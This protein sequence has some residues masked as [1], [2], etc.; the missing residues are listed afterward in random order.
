VRTRSAHSRLLLVVSIAVFL[1]T[2]FYS[3]IT[4]LLP[5]LSHD[6]HL[7][8]LTAGVLTAS[9]PAGMLVASLPAGALAVRRGPR[10]T[11]ITGIC[12]LVLST[13]AFGLLNS[14]LALG[15][16]RFV[17]GIG[18][19]CSWAGGLAWIVSATPPERRGAVM[20]R[21]L[22]TSIAGALFGPAIGALASVTG[23]G[24]LFCV[25]AVITSLLLIP[26]SKLPDEHVPSGQSVT[27]V[28]RL[29]RKPA[30][31]GAMWLMVLPAIV[32]GVFNV[33]GPLQ[34]HALGAGA[35]VIGLTF[36]V[37]AAIESLL[38]PVAGRFSDRHGRMLPLQG[39]AVAIAIG[40]ACFT[41]PSTVAA[42]CVLMIVTFSML[43]IFWAPVMALVADVAEINGIDQAHAAALMN[44]AWA[45]GQIIGAGL[46]GAT[47]KAFGDA[48]PT[49]GVTALCLLT[50]FG[51][52]RPTTARDPARGPDPRA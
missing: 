47:A 9:Y 2:L 25:L 20:G 22:G 23:R 51:L 34:L 6:L 28:L 17:E 49:L 33:L 4:P 38:S 48:V 21:A 46:G 7:T 10:F 14:G 24:V 37:A 52:R 11:L 5:Q 31:A 29:L 43:G 3:V 13:I 40:M 45:A 39:G 8:K 26:I 42:L 32:S 12:L 27:D 1:D 44:L 36:L 16:A 35:G 19:A 50:L 15:V 18:G 30:L 41:L